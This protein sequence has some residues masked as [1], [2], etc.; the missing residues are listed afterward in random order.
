MEEEYEEKR[1]RCDLLEEELKSLKQECTKVECD[2]TTEIK[3]LQPLS[4]QLKVSHDHVLC[5]IMSVVLD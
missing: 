5:I 3:E 2:L 4:E 1:R